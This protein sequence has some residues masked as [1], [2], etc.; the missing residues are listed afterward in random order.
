[1]AIELT[2]LQRAEARIETLRLEVQQK[3]RRL[4]DY[5]E[6]VDSLQTRISGLIAQLHQPQCLDDLIHSPDRPG[7]VS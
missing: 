1:M 2:A 3:D 5:R 7:Q 4:F 6:E